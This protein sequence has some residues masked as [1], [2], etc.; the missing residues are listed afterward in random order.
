MSSFSLVSLVY[1]ITLVMIPLLSKQKLASGS[2]NLGGKDNLLVY[3]YEGQDSST[4]SEGCCSLLESDND[5]QFLNNLG[6]KFKTLAE[7]C[8]GKRIPVEVKEISAHF[9]SAS[10]NTQSSVSSK[11]T[12]QQ[13]PPLP[14]LQPTLPKAVQT[15]VRETTERSQM[16]KENATAVREGIAAVKGGISNQGQI[17]LLQQQ[18]QQPIYLTAAPMPM[19]YV[20][21]PQVQSTMLLAEAPATGMVLVNAKQNAPT[22]SMIIQGQSVMS[23]AQAQSSGMMLVGTSGVHGG[24]ANLINPGNLSVSQAMV[25]VEGKVPAGSVNVLKGGTRPAGGSS[26]SQRVLVVE[27]PVSS[28][29]HLVQEGGGLSVKSDTSGSQKVFYTMSNTSPSPT[30]GGIVSSSTTAMTKTP[31]YRKVVAQKTREIV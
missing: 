22:N 7:V 8:G 2:E 11:T 15:T 30:Q 27:G 23:G 21:Q 13:L 6:L 17:L 4:G 12:A 1:E 3:D 28:R 19:H 5:L 25:V 24:S 26:G 10:I 16:M 20:V 14:Q 9:P 18:Q 29:G 31:T